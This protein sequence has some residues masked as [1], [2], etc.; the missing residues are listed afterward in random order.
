MPKR[1]LRQQMLAKR[2]ALDF[3]QW[4]SSSLL[5]Q[6]LFLGLA[7]YRQAKT[8][9]L[10]SPLQH[11]VDTA[12]LSEQALADGKKILYPLVCGHEMV[13]RQVDGAHQLE[14]G[15]YGIM[16]PCSVG[17]DHS[18]AAADLIVVPGV[19]FDLN[20]HR[21]GFGKGYYDRFLKDRCHNSVLVGFCHE[22]Q[23]TA[24]QIAADIHDIR[25]DI[26]VTDRRIIRF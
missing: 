19:V 9:A 21:I 22:F 12:L 13:F 18:A 11:E 17:A 7:E 3:E 10:Y 20:G 25:M 24:D 16:E 2:R 15:S 6:R 14:S 4:Q 23:V 5:A 8:I 1:T 26:L